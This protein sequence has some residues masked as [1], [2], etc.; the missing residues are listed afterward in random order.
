M[1]DLGAI[2][3]RAALRQPMPAPTAQPQPRTCR[4]CAHRAG[5]G[6]CTEPEAAGLWDR[7]VIVWAPPE[8]ATECTA[9]ERRQ[10]AAGG[11]P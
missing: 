4:Q 5:H 2:R 9:F 11:Q 10:R 6:N 1:L 7:W 8:H 3:A